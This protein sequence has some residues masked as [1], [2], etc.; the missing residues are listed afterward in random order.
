MRAARVRA[1]QRIAEGGLVY[2]VL[3]MMTGLTMLDVTLLGGMRSGPFFAL[4]V[5][6][7]CD[8]VL[9]SAIDQTVPAA[10]GGS[11]HVTAVAE[12][13]AALGHEVHVLASPSDA[14]P[15]RQ[16]A[17]CGGRCRRP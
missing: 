4:L 5:K 2:R 8:E 9:Y 1:K 7:R 14:A 17:S 10:H 15:F 6:E 3:R 11:V 16:V 12:G 13:L